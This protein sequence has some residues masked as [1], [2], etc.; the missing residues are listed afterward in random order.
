[1][2]SAGG[3]SIATKSGVSGQLSCC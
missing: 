2:T 3:V 1:M